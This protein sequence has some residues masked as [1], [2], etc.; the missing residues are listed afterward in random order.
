MD[1]SSTQMRLMG[2][3]VMAWPLTS[4]LPLALGLLRILRVFAATMNIVFG[5][6]HCH[7]QIEFSSYSVEG[8]LKIYVNLNQAY[9]LP[10]QAFI[11]VRRL[12]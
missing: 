8:L 11:L 6:Q 2:E 12:Q 7:P 9:C 4:N 1:L 3:P 10:L 5:D